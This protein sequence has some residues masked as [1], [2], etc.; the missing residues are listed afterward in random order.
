MNLDEYPLALI[1]SVVSWCRPP[2]VSAVGLQGTAPERAPR[3]RRCL[4]A[5]GGTRLWC[6][7]VAI[8]GGLTRVGGWALRFVSLWLLLVATASCSCEYQRYVVHLDI[9][10]PDDDYVVVSLHDNLPYD[11]DASGDTHFGEGESE[12]NYAGPAN[13]Q[14]VL[15][16]SEGFC[17]GAIFRCARYARISA[18]IDRDDSDNLRS[19]VG[20]AGLV[21]TATASDDVKRTLNGLRSLSVPTSSD[22]LVVSDLLDCDEP[23]LRVGLSL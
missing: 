3:G 6:S 12:V 7:F 19:V 14:M 10:E 1:S 16:S 17:S 21:Y 5:G 2:L 9:A 23:R 4:C 20:P 13:Q 11:H 22:S 15:Y 18:Y 8:R